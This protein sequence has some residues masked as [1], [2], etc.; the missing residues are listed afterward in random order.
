MKTLIAL[1]VKGVL[2][3]TKTR[4][5]GLTSAEATKRLQEYGPNSIPHHKIHSNLSRF[6]AYL[7]DGFSL[8][9]LFA[10]VLAFLSAMI[11]VGIVILGIVIMNAG[12]SLLQ[13]VRAEKAMEALKGW[14]PE[15]AKLI[16]SMMTL[17]RKAGITLITI[18]SN[19]II[20]QMLPSE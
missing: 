4:L 2:D 1:P 13:E 20:L 6:L 14:V 17:H 19:P 8:L 3:F 15:W 7:R 12:F 18:R 9:L 10:S 5:E 11:E 16:V